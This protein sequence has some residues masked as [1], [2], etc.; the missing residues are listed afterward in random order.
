MALEGIRFADNSLLL[1]EPHL[2]GGRL[3]TTYNEEVIVKVEDSRVSVGQYVF[4][5]NG[6]LALTSCLLSTLSAMKD[7]AYEND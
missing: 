3:R 6:A 1:Y 2:Q 4:T 7:A 5:E